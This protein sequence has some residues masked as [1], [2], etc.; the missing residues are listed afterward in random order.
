MDEEQ[1]R[2]RSLAVKSLVTSSLRRAEIVLSI[3]GLAA[4]IA[5]LVV[6]AGLPVTS[7]RGELVANFGPSFNPLGGVVVTV[8][9]AVGLVGA[10]TRRPLL[11]LSAAGGFGLCALQVI[12]QF[13]RDTNWL[14]SR[15]SNLSLSLALAIGLGALALTERAAS[16][17][18]I[19][20]S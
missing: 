1:L 7:S 16:G 19:L 18:G 6:A 8:V 20:R 14:G 10:V 13:G 9:A 4:G 11:V 15:G 5:G 17:R 3:V 12:V 2:R